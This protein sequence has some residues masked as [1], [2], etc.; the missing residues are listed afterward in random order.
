[1]GWGGIE[2]GKPSCSSAHLL[3][4]MAKREGSRAGLEEPWAVTLVHWKPPELGLASYS[5]QACHHL[6]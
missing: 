4:V 5:L 1:M 3:P 6:H 2:R